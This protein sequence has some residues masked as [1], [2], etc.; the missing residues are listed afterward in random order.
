MRDERLARAR[1]QQLH[2]ARH[3]HTVRLVTE[4]GAEVARLG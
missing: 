1:L 3:G 2:Q 4:T